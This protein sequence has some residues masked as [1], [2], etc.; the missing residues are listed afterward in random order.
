MAKRINK[1]AAED[2]TEFS[3]EREAL[4]HDHVCMLSAAIEKLTTYGNVD[5]QQLLE[6]LTNGSLGLDVQHFRNTWDA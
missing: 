3:T 5:P 6:E 2:G 4:R 1:W